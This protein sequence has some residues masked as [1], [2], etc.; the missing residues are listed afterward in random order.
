METLTSGCFTCSQLKWKATN[1]LVNQLGL[2]VLSTCIWSPSYVR[3]LCMGY[4]LVEKN[5]SV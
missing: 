3:V 2:S 1:L 5:Y 4:K